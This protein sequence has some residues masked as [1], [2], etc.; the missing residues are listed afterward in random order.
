MKI[1]GLD[2]H[3]ANPGD[4]NW[5]WL[6]EFGEYKIYEYS[7][8]DEV[9]EKAKDADI[10]IDNKVE[11]TADILKQLPNLKLISLLSTG[12]N[13][14][15][16]DAARKCNISV[17]N[18]PAYSTNAVAQHVFAFI[19]EYTNQV[20]HYT[21]S[22]KN[23]DWENCSQFCYWDKPL[24]ELEGKTIGIIGY[25]SIGKRVS[26]IAKAFG[27]NIIVNTNHPP[28]DETDIT[29]ADKDYL[30]KNSDFVTIH[31]PLNKQT[32]GMVNSEF[33]SKMKNTA[34]LINTSRGPVV[35]EDDLKYALEN[36]IIAGAGVDVLENEPPKDDRIA[37]CETSFLTPHVAWA[38]L[39]T[40][41]RLMN[42]CK[43]NIRAFING[44]PQNVV[45]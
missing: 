27:M 9:I 45:N 22:V 17:T 34:F 14:V 15:D 5:D 16:C 32:E 13:V 39:E 36:N 35:N 3:A 8:P 26:Q 2:G 29:F 11:L 31:C 44:T 42:I 25:G 6:E 28:K 20:G 23:G 30:L 37:G 4:L 21:K 40:R 18:I 1:I 38:P 10:I 41:T 43:E 7:T 33:L 12:Y 19:L 24:Y